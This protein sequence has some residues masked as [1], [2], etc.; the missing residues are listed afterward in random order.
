M[1]NSLIAK[2]ENTHVIL[3]ENDVAEGQTVLE[4]AIGLMEGCFFNSGE[5]GE[6]QNTLDESFVK[7]AGRLKADETGVK[8]YI[9]AEEMNQAGNDY[10]SFN[11]AYW[12]VVNG[13]LGWK[14]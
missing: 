10:S 12:S 4:A 9:T 6:T 13:V 11:T 14:A 7:E 5:T 3:A 2:K 1:N 8:R